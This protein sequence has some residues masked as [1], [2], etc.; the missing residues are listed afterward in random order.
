[1]TLGLIILISVVLV[2]VFACMFIKGVDNKKF[3]EVCGDKLD[4]DEYL[5]GY[6]NMCNYYNNGGL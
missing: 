2:T 4:G 5:E 1:M 3:C 6:C